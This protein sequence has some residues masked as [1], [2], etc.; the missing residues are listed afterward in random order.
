MSFSSG[1][2]SINSA[3]QPVVTGTVISSTAFN[4][5]TADLATG[6]STCVLKDGTQTLTANIPMGGFKLTGLGAG[7]ASGNSMRYEQVLGVVTTAGDL[8]YASAAG[9]LA[10]LGIGAAG[11]SLETNA[12]ATAPA[13]MPPTASVAA[14]AT[15]MDPWNS[16]ETVLT[17]SAVTFTDIAD[18]DYAGQVAW[19]YMN[20]AHVWTDGAVFDV[21]GGATYTTAIGD[22]VRINAITVS[23]FDVTIFPANG[24]VVG[25]AGALPIT[26]G[27]PQATTSGTSFS[28]TGIPAGVKKVT[29]SI[30]GVSLSGSD[31]LQ[32]QI[33]PVAGVETSGYLGSVGSGAT[34]GNFTAGFGLT[35]SGGAGSIHHG[36][37]T[38]TL[39]NASTNIWTASGTLGLSNTATAYLFA[40]SK[41]LAGA[42]SVIKLMTNGSDTFDAGEVNISYE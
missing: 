22:W 38:L 37:L 26:L 33:G 11:A 31:A 19:V 8:V 13:W 10:R 9:A 4:A 17:G 29:M 32:V 12:G 25:L 21:Q 30:V 2:F 1:T 34:F 40:Y 39:E 28:F 7:S 42:L 18:A 5:F 15:T 24:G 6:L 3:G 36:T 41:P 14:H 20:A 35:T 27:T 23:T 16:R